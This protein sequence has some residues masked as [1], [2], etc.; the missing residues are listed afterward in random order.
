[1]DTKEREFERK[2][3]D[4]TLEQ[5]RRQLA[6]SN[7][8]FSE[9]Q[10]E[11]RSALRE[12]WEN[13]GSNSGD[14]AQMIEAIGRQKSV[15]SL[16][17]L[18]HRQL[19]RMIDSPYFG[20]I[21]FTEEQDKVV[22]SEKIY[23]GISTLT[24]PGTGELL[25]YDWRSPVA[26]M[27][28]DFERG[29]ARYECPAGVIAGVITL[30]RQYKIVS[31]QLQYM[32][33]SNLKIDDEMLQEIL[34]KSADDKMH[35]IVTSIQRE[36][37]RVMRDDAHRVVFVQGPAGS[38]KTSIA[39]HRVAY[40][41]YRERD[42]LTSKNALIL[43]PNHIFS[44]YISNVLPEIGEENVRQ[45]TFRDYVA[46]VGSELPV[47]IEDRTAQLEYLLS[48]SEDAEF[49]T[50]VANIK[51]KSSPQFERIIEKLAAYLQE[52]LVLDYPAIEFRGQVIFSKEDWKNYYFKSFSFLPAARRLAKIRNLIQLRM[53]PVVQALRE[54]KV[55]EI[56]AT[57]EEVNEKTIK[58]L[59]RI[60]ARDVLLPL[61][62]EIDKLVELD[63]FTMYRRI[64]SD[65]SWLQQFAPEAVSLTGW[66][67]IKKQTLAFLDN[68]RIPYE[69]SFAFL[70]FQG[71]IEGFPANQEIRHLVI[72]EAQ[73]YTVLQYK[74]LKQLFPRCS[75]TILGDPA[76]AV[77]P[78]LQ[79]ADFEAA[80]R[81]IDLEDPL[82]FRLTQ[83]YRSTRE[84]R[85]F[86][87]AL[88]PGTCPEGSVDRHGPLPEV[89]QLKTPDLVPLAIERTVS[90][91]LKEGWQS[92]GI[93]CLTAQ[94]AEAIY[95]AL[96]ERLK[97]SLI[98]REEDEFRRG[99]VIIPS[100]LAKGLEFD[101]VL[102]VI[103]NSQSYQREEQRNILYT[104]C[105]RAL[106]RLSLFCP[107]P[108]IPFIQQIDA[109]LYRKR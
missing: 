25:V 51:Y 45:T 12:Y 87:Q 26:G 28:Y 85:A 35:T 60:A 53:R 40:L 102:A 105:T 41:L 29:P 38:G 84:I 47:A 13:I 68:G 107:G 64:F 42:S 65:D 75:W 24:N 22:N 62:S 98:A 63:A 3:L 97:V 49:R 52:R 56:A 50:R 79:T 72:D 100:Y 74:I 33:D 86:C 32:F 71:I 34:S 36:Q 58:V 19:S 81:V 80:S 8:S 18:R 1:M 69:D 94:D 93:V 82:F 90:D 39:L 23:I 44:D 46:R 11:L 70:Y 101:A 57:A 103:V 59:A 106:H 99:V 16:A 61:I 15:A 37:N 76:Q 21:D 91:Y 104:V 88:L 109:D 20:R 96:K 78:Y 10:M 95:E 43:S 27:F 4:A 66:T 31:G 73:D 108:L 9:S 54:E 5:I 2:R 30:K 67:E 7:D 92:I 77:H 48:S 89:V 55:E 83:S 17:H 14:E 6:E